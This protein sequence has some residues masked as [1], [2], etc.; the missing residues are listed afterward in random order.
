MGLFFNLFLGIVHLLL[1]A[2]DLAGLLV[3]VHL[4]CSWWQ[5]RILV[6]V[7]KVGEPLVSALTSMTDRLWNKYFK[8]RPSARGKLVILLLLLAGVRVFVVSLYRL[9]T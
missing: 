9:I 6:A 1:L 5:N 7:D 3:I 2:I 8:Y 4:V